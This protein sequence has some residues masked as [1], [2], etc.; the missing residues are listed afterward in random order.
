MKMFRALALVP[1]DKLEDFFK[2]LIDSK[3][4]KQPFSDDPKKYKKISRG[5]FETEEVFRA[6]LEKFVLYMRV[7]IVTF[8]IIN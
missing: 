6:K 2:A 7:S 4:F 8:E 1:M 3:E 5:K